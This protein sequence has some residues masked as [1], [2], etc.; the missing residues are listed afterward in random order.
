MNA[1]KA[2]VVMVENADKLFDYI[3]QGHK[4]NLTDYYPTANILEVDL[5][6]SSSNPITNYTQQASFFQ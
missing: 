3:S 5:A 1:Q 4:D 2:L 6:N